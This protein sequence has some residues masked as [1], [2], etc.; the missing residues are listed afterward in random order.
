MHMSSI[1]ERHTLGS[2]LLITVMG[3]SLPTAPL[4]L[5]DAVNGNRAK[6]CHT[7]MEAV[8]PNGGNGGL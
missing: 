6:L 4:P 5:E 2:G 8:P 3:G 1:Q 7:G